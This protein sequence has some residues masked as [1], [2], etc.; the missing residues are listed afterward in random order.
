MYCP[1]QKDLASVISFVT[2]WKKLYKVGVIS[3]LNV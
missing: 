2:L 1:Y 3:F